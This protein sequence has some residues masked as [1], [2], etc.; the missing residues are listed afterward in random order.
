M[1]N[2]KVYRYT[3][4]GA[5]VL[6]SKP[7]SLITLFDAV[8]VNGYGE[9]DVTTSSISDGLI[10]LNTENPHGFKTDDWVLVSGAAEA[11]LNTEHRVTI[12]TPTSMKFRVSGVSGS[13]VAGTVKVKRAP[14]G[15]EKPFQKANVGVYRSKDLSSTRF[16]FRIRDEGASEIQSRAA[17][18]G[19]FEKM[20][21]VDVGE[22][23]FGE[24]KVVI[25][26][27][28]QDNDKTGGAQWML[29]SDGKIVY[30]FTGRSYQSEL[31]RLGKDMVPGGWF[32]FGDYISNKPG[33]AYNAMLDGVN[34]SYS[35]FDNNGVSS[36][37]MAGSRQNNRSYLPVVIAR[38][39]NELPVAGVAS[40]VT[41]GAPGFDTRSKSEPT[42]SARDGVMML[43]ACTIY[44]V[45]GRDAVDYGRMPGVYSARTTGIGT[46]GETLVRNIEGLPGKSLLLMGVRYDSSS[47]E[48]MLIDITGPWE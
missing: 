33:D 46:Y 25:Y 4:A 20:T 41:Y 16:F 27:G 35:E 28:L 3:D 44:S 45:D 7:G 34:V 23:A 32:A 19:G 36:L 42:Y 30:F 18:A 39:T 48:E 47:I 11:S 17:T 37:H 10:T 2:V 12:E 43:T 26:K 31:S 21:D 40:Y 1:A 29:I 15:F 13:S 14:A 6:A 5:P 8:L 22:Q 38:H 24:D 9:H